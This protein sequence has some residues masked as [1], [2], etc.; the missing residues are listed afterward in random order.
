M[1]FDFKSLWTSFRTGAHGVL[2][3][4]PVELLLAAG[5]SAALVLCYECDWELDVRLAAVGWGAVL[6]LAVNLLTG[7]T[8]WRRLYWVAWAPLVPLAL[9]PGFGAW[10]ESARGAITVGLLTPLALLACRRAVANRRFVFDTVILLRAALLALLFA[11]VALGLFQAILWSAAYIFGFGGAAWVEH[12]AVDTWIVTSTFVVPLLFMMML[13]R[14]E[15]SEVHGTRILEVLLDWIVSPAVLIYAAI[16]YLYAFKILVTWSLPEGGVAYLVFGFTSVALAVKALQELLGRR[17]YGWF[18][19]RLSLFALPAAVLFWIGTL[20]RVGEYGLTEPRVYLVVCGAVM[21]FCLAIFL[22]RRTGRYLWVVLFAM[23]LFAAVAYVPALEPGRVAVRSQQARAERIARSLDRLDSAGRLVLTPVP[24]ADTVRGARYRELYEALAYLYL[25][26]TLRLAAFGLSSTERYAELFP[27]DFADYV[28]GWTDRVP[29]AGTGGATRFFYLPDD[30]EYA[31]GDGYS[32]LWLPCYS[33]WAEFG[34]DTL[35]VDVGGERI[36]IAGAELLARQLARVGVA[37]CEEL[38][39]SREHIEPLMD[40]RDARCR[41]IFSDLSL[42]RTDS[43]GWRI[44]GAQLRA[45]ML[46][47]PIRCWAKSSACGRR[48]PG[49]SRSAYVFRETCG[50]SIPAA[51]RRCGR[52]RSSRRR[53][54]GSKRPANGFRTAGP[55]CLLS[56]PRRRRRSVSRCCAAP[57]RPIFRSASGGSPPRRDCGMR[58]SRSAPRGR[59][60]EVVRGGT[61]Y[62]S[63]CS[64]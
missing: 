56:C 26:D 39:D 23:L 42:E 54:R 50:S 46:R 30:A 25:R 6:L 15:R 2:R 63:A 62:R 14:W 35:R 33:S 28:R 22:S 47:W 17:I 21:T 43:L 27:S 53:S 31:L 52:W 57:R 64:L 40:Y 8:P 5:L 29:A 41:I 48:A 1:V 10:L 4:H 36:R 59:S 12:A 13:D 61:T 58:S 55:L 37:S 9:W 44:A 11:Y 18:Y 32:R 60:G 51:C 16:L 34:N 45:V 38:R 7:R 19:D 20:R 49:A 3:R 24:L